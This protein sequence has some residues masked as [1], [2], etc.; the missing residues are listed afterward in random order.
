[1]YDTDP[2][3]LYYQVLSY[4]AAG[5]FKQS[6]KILKT[7]L[8][9]LPKPL[10]G[11]AQDRVVSYIPDI[12]YHIGLAYCNGEKFEKSIYP[13]TKVSLNLNFNLQMFS[14]LI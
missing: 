14:A 13:Y 8:L 5:N 11:E 6:L 4:Y 12:Y 9:N 7:A 1:M 10:E 2:E 3:L